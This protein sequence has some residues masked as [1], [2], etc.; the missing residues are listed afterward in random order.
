[1]QQ[2]QQ[3]QALLGTANS[4][5]QRERIQAC[6]SLLC[7]KHCGWLQ[8]CQETA[9][10]RELEELRHRAEAVEEQEKKEEALR[11]V[12]GHLGASALPSICSS[13]DEE[14]FRGSKGDFPVKVQC[15][16]LSSCQPLRF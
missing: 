14:K 16:H 12:C 4:A 10:L 8:R 1:M 7:Q 13:L 3:A 6:R 2:A 9:E 5:D 11:S 15:E